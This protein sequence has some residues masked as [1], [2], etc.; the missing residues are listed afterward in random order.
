MAEYGQS[1]A[2]DADEEPPLAQAA[3]G[4]V[5]ALTLLV[6]FSLMFV[7]VSYFWVAFPVGFGGVLPFA[8]A[9]AKHYERGRGRDRG[10]ADRSRRGT[11]SDTE[12]A[13]EELRERYARGE[14]SDEQFERRLERL[15]ETESVA[16]AR[17]YAERVRAEQSSS[18]ERERELE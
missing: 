15:L 11:G 1:P 18:R 12:G 4:A 9:L 16:D 2:D 7:G 10:T 3:A 14:L 13:L 17:E 5:T 6:A 8:V